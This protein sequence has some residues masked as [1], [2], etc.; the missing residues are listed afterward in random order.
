MK[1]S[2]IR[3]II[4]LA[5]ISVASGL[6][7]AL[8]YNFTIPSINAIAA[9]EQEEAI[10]EVLPGAETF[11]VIEGADI[12]MYKGLDA[13][14]GY[15]GVAYVIEGGGFQGI[16]RIMVGLDVE[17]EV[18]TGIKI[19]SHTETPGLGARITEDWFQGQFAG[20]SIN[21]GFVA[22][23]D[24]DAITGATISSRAV[25]AIIRDSI[26]PVVEQYKAL[27]GAN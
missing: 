23:E 15:A 21:D 10:L 20:K 11:E 8:T 22:K 13:S 26:P 25:S 14:G 7:L 3:L 24:V 17:N 19:L 9:A 4:V 18:L 12:P 16:I 2:V 27:G 1:D 6:V 5:I